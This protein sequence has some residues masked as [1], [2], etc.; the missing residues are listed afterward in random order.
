MQFG[1]FASHQ[2]SQDFSNIWNGRFGQ[3]QLLPKENLNDRKTVVNRFVC[4][5]SAKCVDFGLEEGSD[6]LWFHKHAAPINA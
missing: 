2:N 5:D 1:E 3:N 4:G 6:K